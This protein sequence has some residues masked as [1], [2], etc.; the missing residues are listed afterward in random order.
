MHEGYSFIKLQLLTVQWGWG[1]R[2]LLMQVTSPPGWT[3]Q[4]STVGRMGR[5]HLSG[6]TDSWAMDVGTDGTSSGDSAV[7]TGKRQKAAGNTSSSQQPP[8]ILMRDLLRVRLDKVSWWRWAT[9]PRRIRQASKR[10]PGRGELFSKKMRVQ[11]VQ[12]GKW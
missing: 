6:G 8:G 1:W 7:P 10:R 9:S 11:L 3:G 2:G 12:L 5:W 4:T